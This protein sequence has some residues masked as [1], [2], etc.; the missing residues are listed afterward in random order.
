MNRYKIGQLKDRCGLHLSSWSCLPVGWHRLWLGIMKIYPLALSYWHAL[1][2][3][4]FLCL[5]CSRSVYTKDLSGLSVKLDYNDVSVTGSVIRISVSWQSLKL[6]LQARSTAFRSCVMWHKWA[7]GED[8]I[9]TSLRM[10]VRCNASLNT[11]ITFEWDYTVPAG[12]YAMSA[13]RLDKAECIQTPVSVCVLIML[14][15]EQTCLYHQLTIPLIMLEKPIHY[16]PSMSSFCFFL[17]LISN[18]P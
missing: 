10:L 2:V 17:S 11:L 7:Q 6:E 4:D 16:P 8:D 12:K 3:W 13:W 14:F 18:A 15:S 9:I 1:S 5:L